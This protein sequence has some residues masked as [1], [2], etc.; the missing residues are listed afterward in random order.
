[1]IYMSQKEYEDF[2]Y[3][4]KDDYDKELKI[5]DENIKVYSKKKLKDL[6]FN[7][8]CQICRQNAGR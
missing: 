1:M 7:I 2:L 4:L 5:N 3:V 6:C 8:G